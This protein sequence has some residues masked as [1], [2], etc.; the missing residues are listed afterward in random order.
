MGSSRRQLYCNDNFLSECQY[1]IIIYEVWA[2]SIQT[3][4]KVKAEE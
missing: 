1:K 2:L 3:R 4:A